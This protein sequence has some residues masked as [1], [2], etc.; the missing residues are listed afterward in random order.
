MRT[1]KSYVLRA[2]RMTVRQ[3][4]GWQEY[5]PRYSL[6]VD[7]GLW[8][9]RK[10]FG[11]AAPTILEI[12]FGMGQSLAQMAQSQADTNFIGVE[13]HQAGVGALAADIAELELTN[14]RVVAFDAVA[15]LRDCI[16][17]ASLAGVQ[18]Y[19]PDPWPKKKHHKRRLIQPELVQLLVKKIKPGGT[20]HCATDWEEYAEYMLQV[21][22]QVS[23][24]KNTSFIDTYVPRPNS[25]PLTKFEQRGQRLGHGIWD[26]L[27]TVKS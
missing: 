10:L 27:F 16:A 7:R 12:G 14:L 17:D 23:S 11:N 8:D 2:G 24:L 9:F 22:K 25:R 4:Q 18:I 15:I 21:L 6:P 3:Q 1:I 26:L 20:L 5:Y 19:F 13:V